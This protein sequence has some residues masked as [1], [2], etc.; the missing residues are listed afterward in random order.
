MVWRDTFLSSFKIIFLSISKGRTSCLSCSTTTLVDVGIEMEENNNT[1]FLN[2]L[3]LKEIM[4]GIWVIVDTLTKSNHFIAIR[5]DYSLE[6]IPEFYINEIV[7]VHGIPMSIVSD[8]DPSFTSRF[9]GTLQEA[10][11]TKF[12]FS[13]SFHPQT[14]G[15]TERVIQIFEDMIRAWIIVFEG[16]PEKNWLW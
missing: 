14:D 11:G 12:K 5:M 4:M 16:C 1:L 9:W 2:S 3:V 8:W 10:L 13:T 7:G 15:K 6:R